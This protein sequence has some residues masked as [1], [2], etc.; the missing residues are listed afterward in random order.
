[1]RGGAAKGRRRRHRQPPLG[2][3]VQ[4]RDLA[5]PAALA[6][7]LTR[8]R[9]DHRDRR[10]ARPRRAADPLDPRQA[11]RVRR[12]QPLSNQTAACC[13]PESQ[14]GLIAL[15]DFVAAEAAASRRS[16]CATSR[17][18]CATRTTAYYPRAAARCLG[19][20]PSRRRG[21]RPVRV[22]RH[23]DSRRRTGGVRQAARRPGGRP[24]RPAAG[25]G[26]RT[27]EGLRRLPHRPLHRQRRGPVRLRP[28]RPRPRG[29]RR[30]RG[31]RRG[32]DE[33]R[34][35]RPRRHAVLAPVRQVRALPL[36][37][38]EHLPRHPRGAEQGPP[39]GRQHAPQPR[40]RAH[41][42]L[43]GHEHVRRG[44]GHARDRPGEGR[45]RGPARR[46]LHARLRRHHRPRCRPLHRQG[47]AGLHVRRL[48]RRAGRARRGRRLPAGRRRADHR[49]GPVRGPTRSTPRPRAP[50]TRWSAAPTRS[51]RSSR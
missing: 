35:R 42:P 38:D 49:R 7:R 19:V 33:R 13:P 16:T 9:A 1:M 3:R 24:G 41:P 36:A 14:D 25:R 51:S 21:V 12:G 22:R 44:D 2:D 30:G 5:R 43:H 8:S 31:S 32:R 48:R 47:R 6:D 10:P 17:S 39:P 46:R 18:G 40:R 4:P 27:A 11:G 26:A 23:E 34:A 50:P 15:I 29:R 37:Q 45:P 28:H 20:A